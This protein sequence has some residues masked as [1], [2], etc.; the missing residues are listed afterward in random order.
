MRLSE[1]RSTRRPDYSIAAVLG[2]IFLFLGLGGPGFWEPWESGLVQLAEFSNSHCSNAAFFWVP[3][4][5]N[6]LVYKPLALIWSLIGVQHLSA[7]PTEFLLRL[8]G[9]LVGLTLLL[10]TFALVRRFFS[11]AAGFSTLLVLLSTP[12]FVFGA[13]LLSGGIWTIAA[14][15]LPLELYLL[16]TYAESTAVRRVY[17]GLFGASFLFAFVAGGLYP[18]FVVVLT[19]MVFLLWK[20]DKAVLAGFANAGMAVGIAISAFGIYGVFSQYQKYVPYALED[21]IPLTPKRVVSELSIDRVES[22]GLRDGVL[23]GTFPEDM[24]EVVGAERFVLSIDNQTLG[25]SLWRAWLADPAEMTKLFKAMGDRGWLGE[26]GQPKEFGLPPSDRGATKATLQFFLNDLYDPSQLSALDTV[27]VRSSVGVTPNLGIV[28]TKPESLDAFLLRISSPLL[29][30]ELVEEKTAELTKEPGQGN[31]QALPEPA[32]GVKVVEL[33]QV[34]T[35]R[36]GQEVTLIGPSEEAPGWS[37]IELSGGKRGFVRSEI[38]EKKASIKHL[39][40]ENTVRF[41]GFGMF[42]WI[43]F[44]PFALAMLMLRRVHDLADEVDIAGDVGDFLLIF[45]SLAVLGMDLG[46]S[47]LSNTVF[48]GVVPAAVSC[49]LLLGSSTLWQRI[50]SAPLHRKFIGVVAMS[51]LAV[52]VHDYKTHPWLFI[53]SYLSEPTMD[54]DK[55]LEV[56]ML[57]FRLF[58]VVVAV[59]IAG[60]FFGAVVFSNRMVGKAIAFMRWRFQGFFARVDALDS[61]APWEV[62]N[63]QQRV[64]KIV[65]LPWDY[66]LRWVVV[67]LWFVA[68]GFRQ[69]RPALLAMGLAFGIMSAFVYL[70]AMSYH[71]TQKSLLERYTEVAKEGEPLFNLQTEAQK[72][73][74]VFSDCESGYSCV[75]GKCTA[76]ATS[77]YLGNIENIREPKLIDQMLEDGRIFA[78]IPRKKLAHVNAEYRKKFEPGKRSNLAVLD[79]RSSRYL[80]V[81]DMLR[82]GEQDENF[83]N[84]LIL[85]SEPTPEYRPKQPVRFTNGLVFLGYDLAP[86]TVGSGEELTITY[87]FQVTRDVTQDWQM[88]LHIDYPGN[89]INGDHYPGDGN[90][91]TNTW[92]AGDYV[93]D[94]QKLE[95]DRGSSAGLYELWFGFFSSGDNRLKVESGERDGK[96]RVKMGM[97]KVSGG[98]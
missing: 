84:D 76:E 79:S 31:P 18:L 77:F 40:F 91:H 86:D 44:A 55:D 42:P 85:N 95:V 23:V 71:L 53:E 73:C 35:V 65:T 98:I 14:A 13:R 78:I 93:K 2:L 89:R 66:C 57:P 52:L 50:D 96:D 87:Y 24:W 4:T 49:G 22:L 11:R 36:N 38:L 67:V 59:L 75:R 41:I 63:P 39:G 46:A 69:I 60:Y 88:F 62:L 68:Q 94:V 83:L 19:L 74:K 8:P 25:T 81:S 28:R 33:E 70:P 12:M 90:F 92:L 80:L 6:H 45:L 29:A 61:T 9:A 32:P 97:L 26:D 16:S 82:D 48:L 34:G 21:R 15:T 54:W 51:L 20:R 43:L 64:W 72:S 1:R 7:Q 5:E 47:L 27:T 17:G 58:R 30:P 56:M 10:L 3:Q 37:E